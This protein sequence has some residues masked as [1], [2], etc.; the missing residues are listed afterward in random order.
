M[1]GI[2]CT[3]SLFIKLAVF[4]EDLKSLSKEIY[5]S[6]LSIFRYIL[7]PVL[8]NDEVIVIHHKYSQTSLGA[9]QKD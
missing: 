2:D 7:I 9:F 6:G 5:L 3:W 8:M 4:E 1:L